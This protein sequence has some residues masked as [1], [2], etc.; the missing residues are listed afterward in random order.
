MR[1]AIRIV[2]R[3]KRSASKSK[4]GLAEATSMT[5]TPQEVIDETDLERSRT[6]YNYRAE[7]NILFYKSLE[8]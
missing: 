1:K 5:P 3:I 2:N 7:R 8:L 4:N 6:D